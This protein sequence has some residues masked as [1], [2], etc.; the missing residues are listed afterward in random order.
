[1]TKHERNNIIIE[2][3]LLSS[4]LVLPKEGHSDAAVHIMAYV[5]QKSNY[6]LGNDPSYPDRDHSIFKKHEWSDF[7]PD[8]KEVIRVNAPESR[9]NELDICMIVG[10][11]HAGD[12]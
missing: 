12:K 1:M 8:A 3:L 5:G 7:Y 4:H 6:G 2:V 10:G 11:D 9:G